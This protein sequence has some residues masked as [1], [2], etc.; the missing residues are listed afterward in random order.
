MSQNVWN[1]YD[2]RNEGEAVET[3]LISEQTQPP[4]PQ[5]WQFPLETQQYPNYYEVPMPQNFPYP[6]TFRTVTQSGDEVEYQLRFFPGPGPFY[7][8]P[9]FGPV[10]IIRPLPPVP[11][12]PPLIPP[13]FW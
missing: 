2:F 5:T 9:V 4:V 11:F 7:P 3:T 12:L 13:F 6:R 1:P 8:G 10:P